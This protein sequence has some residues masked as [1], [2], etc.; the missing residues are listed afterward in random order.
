[1]ATIINLSIHPSI[2][3]IPNKRVS[4][5]IDESK[6]IFKEGINT[7]HI[8]TIITWEHLLVVS[9]LCQARQIKMNIGYTKDG[10]RHQHAGY[11]LDEYLLGQLFAPE[12]QVKEDPLITNATELYARLGG[13][14]NKDA[15][16]VGA[17]IDKI[18]SITT[19]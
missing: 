10:Q 5:L 17:L 18:V 16:I 15:R 4:E 8:F 12:E 14:G 1:M 3:R 6:E 13:L 11:S 19:H 7:N 2:T 9:Q